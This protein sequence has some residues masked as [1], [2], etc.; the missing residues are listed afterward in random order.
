MIFIRKH[1]SS[2]KIQLIKFE[3][4]INFLDVLD[5]NN[6]GSYLENFIIR[7]LI[8]TITNLEFVFMLVFDYCIL[9]YVKL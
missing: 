3:K 9:V 8:Y 7:K 4:Y 6:M 1:F 2:V 5:F